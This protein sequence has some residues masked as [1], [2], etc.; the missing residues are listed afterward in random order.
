MI[1]RLIA[2]NSEV[3][4]AIYC[5]MD[6]VLVDFEAGATELISSILDGTADPMWT[7]GSKSMM[8]NIERVRA[9]LGEDWRPQNKADLDAKGV[10]QILMSAVSSA[11][12]DFFESLPPLDD[13]INELWPFLN[14]AGVPVH[15]LSA[16]IRGREG[17]RPAEDGKRA[18]CAR[19]L[20]PVPE[21][22][23]IVDA[24][25]KAR[26]AMPDGNVNLLVDDKAKTID[27]WN[28]LGGIGILHPPGDSA[29]SI[30]EIKRR[31][32]RST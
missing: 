1:R 4:G 5:D 29:S 19:Y 13:G 11:P 14:D 15:I 12:G 24:V 20:S 32:G 21:S 28:S 30:S 10:R 2:E 23:I 25:D 6:G 16:P 26:W 22:I 17:T 3:I 8:K 7:A 18:W 31:L 9:D 27:A